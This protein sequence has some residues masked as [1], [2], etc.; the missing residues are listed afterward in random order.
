[1]G[2]KGKTP[3]LQIKTYPRGG[4]RIKGTQEKKNGIENLK[5]LVASE[6]KISDA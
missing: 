3:T 1:L 4:L 2:P 5:R 6:G